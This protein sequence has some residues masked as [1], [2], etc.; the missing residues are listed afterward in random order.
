MTTEPLSPELAIAARILA[1]HTSGQVADA[2]DAT[3]PVIGT[4]VSVTAGGASDGFALVT[5]KRRGQTIT[6]EGFLASYSP[7]VNDRVLCVYAD[8]QLLILGRLVGHP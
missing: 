2:A 3:A 7:A 1:D 4:I 5:V 6:A 8:N